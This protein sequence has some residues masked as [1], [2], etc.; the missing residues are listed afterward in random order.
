MSVHCRCVHARPF[1][2]KRVFMGLYTNVL[3]V[4]GVSVV[5]N[6]VGTMFWKEGEG[7]DGTILCFTLP[8]KEGNGKWHRKM[9]Y[10]HSTV[11]WFLKLNPKIC[12]ID[13]CLGRVWMATIPWA[14]IPRHIDIGICNVLE[15]EHQWCK[16]GWS[17]THHAFGMGVRLA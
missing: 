15:M 8:S 9:Y 1:G 6:N 13:V 16:L 17:W 2:G 5:S 4:V 12:N 14:I 10:K 11:I 7:W 3:C